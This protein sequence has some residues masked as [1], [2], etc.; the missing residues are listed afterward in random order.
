M[1]P[2]RLI[3]QIKNI[4]ENAPNA[5]YIKDKNLQ[6]CYVNQASLAN[7]KLHEDEVMHLLDSEMHFSKYAVHY[8]AQ[9]LAAMQND[10]YYQLDPTCTKNGDPL[11]ALTQKF[12]LKDELGT[13]YG[14]LGFSQ[15]LTPNELLD[16]LPSKKSM[17][18]GKL[19]ITADIKS[20]LLH[21]QNELSD[22]E[23]EVLYYFLQGMSAKTTATLLRITE[24]TVIFHLNNIKD[25]WE[26]N[27]KEAIFRKAVEKGLVKFSTLWHL[28]SQE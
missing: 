21:T 14:V 2:P 6:Y 9:D 8:N 12:P 27:S 7:L 28:I 23:L 1:I 17:L 10:I 15:H 11:F 22:R 24:R 4:F 19:K 18:E 3:L 16:T 5:V 20:L 26:C 13:V 25:K